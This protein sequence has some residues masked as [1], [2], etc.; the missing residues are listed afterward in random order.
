MLALATLAALI[1]VP[2]PS[3]L[4]V[5]VIVALAPLASVPRE[6]TTGRAGW[7]EPWLGLMDSSLPAWVAVSV[8]LVSVAGSGPWLVTVSVYVS[9]W[10]GCAERRLTRLTIARS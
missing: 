1:S 5:S 3:G 9:L 10:P 2:T 8:T 7:H 6:Q 4:V